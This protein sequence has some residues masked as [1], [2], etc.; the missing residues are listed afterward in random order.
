MEAYS[1]CN[2][3]KVYVAVRMDLMADGTIVPRALKWEDGRQYRIDEVLNVSPGTAHKAGGCG[4]CYTVR[5][6]GRQRKL[7]FERNKSGRGS[8]V[9]R[10]FVE[11]V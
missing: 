11:R 9:G 8:I 10:W 3:S 6:C 7:F 1:E 4:D 2:G 5:I